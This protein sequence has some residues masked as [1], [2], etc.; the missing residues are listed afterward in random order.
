M[1]EQFQ[2]LVFFAK[3]G[4]VLNMIGDDLIWTLYMVK[5]PMAIEPSPQVLSHLISQGVLVETAPDDLT[6]AQLT[7][8]L[9]R[10]REWKFPGNDWDEEF[11][12]EDDFDVEMISDL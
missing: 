8:I 1:R 10:R 4:D 2:P 11:D 5:Q 6:D 9:G 3:A 12:D 7:K